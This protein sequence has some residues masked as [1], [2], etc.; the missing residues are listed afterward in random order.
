L[1]ITIEDNGIGR[2]ESKK[3]KKSTAHKSI[4]MEI[5]KSRIEILNN[6]MGTKGSQINIYDLYDEHHHSA[7][8]RAEIKIAT[9]TDLT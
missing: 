1:V 5:T 4:G 2:E 9:N 6:L 8:T 3:I 7:G